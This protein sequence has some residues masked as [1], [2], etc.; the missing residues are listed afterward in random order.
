MLKDPRAIEENCREA[1]IHPAHHHEWSGR[2]LW[3]EGMSRDQRLNLIVQTLLAPNPWIP[4]AD[5]ISVPGLAEYLAECIET[6]RD[7]EFRPVHEH[8]KWQIQDYG[9]GPFCAACGQRITP[10]RNDNE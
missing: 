4:G 3:C 5:F 7:R 1:A 8:E 10:E 2:L 9:D 6:L